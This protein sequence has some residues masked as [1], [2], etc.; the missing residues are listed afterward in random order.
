MPDNSVLPTV[1]IIGAS[2]GIGLALAKEFAAAGSAVHATYRGSEP[3]SALAAIA[4]VATYPL[5]VTDAAGIAAL[6]T[7]LGGMPIDLL[8]HGAAMGDPGF[9]LYDAEPEVWLQQLNINAVA[10]MMVAAALMPN[11]LASTAKRAM[12]I[13]SGLASI[14][15]TTEPHHLV[16]RMSKA[17][18]NMGVR[19]I[20]CAHGGDGI[21]AVA[22]D[23]GWVR[24]DM[25][26]PDAPL[27][28]AECAARF[29]ALAEG[30]TPANNGQFLKCDGQQVPW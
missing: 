10:P 3:P 12:F 20:A 11:I 9:D 22:A 1:L 2:R 24:T 27:A 18:L 21:T 14:A 16:Y 26:G 4:G 25:G 13:T 17:A 6:A 19:Y 29:R 28:P 7:A 5:E 15:Q 23:P 8:I 30:L